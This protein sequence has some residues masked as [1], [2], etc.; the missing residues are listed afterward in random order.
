MFVNDSGSSPQEWQQGKRRP[1]F[2]TRM[3]KLVL[4]STSRPDRCTVVYKRCPENVCSMIENE[5]QLVHS[6]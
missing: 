4:T 1:R 5:E 6:V 3:G 2:A